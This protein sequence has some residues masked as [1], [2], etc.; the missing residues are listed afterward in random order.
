MRLRAMSASLCLPGVCLALLSGCATGGTGGS[1]LLAKPIE[2]ITETGR[3]VKDT[4]YN[5]MNKA[6]SDTVSLLSFGVGTPAANA[7]E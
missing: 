7:G 5:G 4:T 1:G 2:T 6:W 3:D